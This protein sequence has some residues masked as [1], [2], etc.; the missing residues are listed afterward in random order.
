MYLPLL[1]VGI[2]L[3]EAFAGH[4]LGE[5]GHALERALPSYGLVVLIALLFDLRNAGRGVPH[6]LSAK[7]TGCLSVCVPAPCLLL[8][9]LISQLLL[10]VVRSL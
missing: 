8:V 2:I 10:P 1:R 6:G 7:S 9:S 5:P 3:L 4:L